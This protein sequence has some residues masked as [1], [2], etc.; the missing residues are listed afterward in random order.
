MEVDQKSSR[1]VLLFNQG[2]ILQSRSR[3]FGIDGQTSWPGKIHN[4]ADYV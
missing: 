4:I 3:Y 2:W 1:T